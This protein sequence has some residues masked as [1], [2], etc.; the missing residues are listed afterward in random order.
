MGGAL[1]GHYK[2]YDGVKG[3]IVSNV[4][5]FLP[6]YIDPNSNLSQVA[7]IRQKTTMTASEYATYCTPPLPRADDHPDQD[8]LTCP[9]RRRH[10]LGVPAL[11]GSPTGGDL[12][13]RRSTSSCRHRRTRRSAAPAIWPRSARC[14]C[15]ETCASCRSWAPAASA[16]P[17][18]RTRP[19]GRRRPAS[20]AAPCTSAS[21][22]PRMRAC[23]SPRPRP[24]SASSPRRPT[25]WPSSCA[26]SPAARRRCSCST[27]SSASSTTQTRSA[28]CSRRWPT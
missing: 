28:G 26:S 7:M 2:I 17:A 8:R 10:A 14:S 18:W 16:R 22:A 11:L 24:R 9:T 1:T 27:G 23:S 21:T 13:A 19:P 25:S 4:G 5:V 3:I 6:G 15:G 20:P 12:R